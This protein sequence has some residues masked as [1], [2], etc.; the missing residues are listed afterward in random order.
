MLEKGE[1]SGRGFIPISFLVKDI[2]DFQRQF[3]QAERFLNEATAPAIEDRLRL[4]IEA[5]TT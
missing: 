3:I 4:G 1:G 2:T 5:I